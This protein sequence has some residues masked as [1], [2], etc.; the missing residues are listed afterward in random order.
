MAVLQASHSLICRC[1]TFP[2][3]SAIVNQSKE[4]VAGEYSGWIVAPYIRMN[5]TVSGPEGNVERG[6]GGERECGS[7]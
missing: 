4:L 2:Y 6:G 5:R 7:S 1:N 3:P